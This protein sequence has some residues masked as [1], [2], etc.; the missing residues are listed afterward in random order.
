[1]AKKKSRTIEILKSRR[2]A[3]MELAIIMLIIFTAF[4]MLI[5]NVALLQS[6]TGKSLRAREA[7]G[8]ELDAIGEEFV[9]LAREGKGVDEAKTELEQNDTYEYEI[10]EDMTTL[11]VKNGE[12]TVLEVVIERMGSEIKIMEWTR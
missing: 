10:N 11:V 5:A 9:S 6:S 2:G 3:G 4:A 7:E 12:L 8:I 1:M